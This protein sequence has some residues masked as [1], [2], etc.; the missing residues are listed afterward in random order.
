M[1]EKITKKSD[2]ELEIET[3]TTASL[4]KKDLEIDKERIEHD[5]SR[6]QTELSRINN[7]LDY[8]K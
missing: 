4:F 6:F 2:E 8:F 5:I 7:L 1:T 3:T